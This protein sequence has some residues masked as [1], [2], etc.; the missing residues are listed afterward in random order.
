MVMPVAGGVYSSFVMSSIRLYMPLWPILFLP[1]FRVLTLS[2]SA[3]NLLK[4]DG[5]PFLVRQRFFTLKF[6]TCFY[7]LSLPLLPSG[8]LLHVWR[9]CHKRTSSIYQNW[10]QCTL[11]LSF[12]RIS[13]YSRITSLVFHNGRS[14]YYGDTSSWLKQFFYCYAN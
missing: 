3:V 9:R 2:L 6:S 14:T 4:V 5:S 12:N 10:P 1:V 11:R 7:L 8:T 13:L